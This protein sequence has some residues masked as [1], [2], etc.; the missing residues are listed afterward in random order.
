MGLKKLEHRYVISSSSQQTQ[1]PKGWDKAR[2]DRL[3]NNLPDSYY[4]RITGT[5]AANEAD[6]R[7]NLMKVPVV[8]V[9][10]IRA[11]IAAY[12]KSEQPQR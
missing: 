10:T 12:H 7:T 5:T 9:P 4:Q 1:L 8:L 3:L 11:L 2:V 6:I